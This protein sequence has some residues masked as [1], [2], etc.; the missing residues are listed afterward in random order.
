MRPAGA[1]AAPPLPRS[2]VYLWDFLPSRATQVL[3]LELRTKGWDV[4]AELA[5]EQRGPECGYVAVQLTAQ[6]VRQGR[7]LTRDEAWAGFK[8]ASAGVGAANALL[9]RVGAAVQDF[10]AEAQYLEVNG[11]GELLRE[12]LREPDFTAALGRL[13]FVGHMDEFLGWVRGSHA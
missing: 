8:L 13:L 4:H 11:V 1:P 10:G 6:M 12:E 2:K 5:T 9:A 3:A 7:A